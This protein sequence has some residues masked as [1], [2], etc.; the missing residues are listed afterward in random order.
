ML[1][2]LGVEL[3][4]LVLG[5]WLGKK[6]LLCA[7]AWAWPTLNLASASKEAVAT[8][9]RNDFTVLLV[10]FVSIGCEFVAI[11]PDN[12]HI[13]D[14]REHEYSCELNTSEKTVLNIMS[15]CIDEMMSELCWD[16]IIIHGQ[17]VKEFIKLM[18]NYNCHYVHP[19][20]R[21]DNVST[22]ERFG[23]FD[24]YHRSIVEESHKNYVAN[25][26]GLTISDYGHNNIDPGALTVYILPF[27]SNVISRSDFDIYLA[28]G[29]M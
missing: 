12:T 13:L 14:T 28:M 23:P 5:L 16:C 6:G 17:P 20:N 7:R 10:C 24:V 3:P 1:I 25:S 29:A 18:H 11:M 9:L 21:Y 15:R 19:H 2:S 8:H 22:L 26:I 27:Q 4:W